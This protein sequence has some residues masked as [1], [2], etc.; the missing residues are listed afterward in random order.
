MRDEST[1]E[2]ALYKMKRPAGRRLPRLRD[3]IKGNDEEKKFRKILKPLSRELNVLDVGCGLGKKY[4]LLES[5]GFARILGVDKNP[6]LVRR[7]VDEGRKVVTPAEFHRSH[8]DTK[9]DLILMSHLIEHF[10]WNELLPFLETYLDHLEDNGF[11]LIVSPVSHTSFY[12]DFDHV[13]PFLPDSIRNIFGPMEQV[14]VRPRHRLELIDLRFRRVPLNLVF[15][16][17]FYVDSANKLPRLFNKLM[18]I[19]FRLS[20]NGIAKTT[21]WLGLFRK[22][23]EV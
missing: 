23:G 15:C 6:D 13:K 11:L 10:Q 16:R 14:Q 21:G 17:S 12:S 22:I 9:F 8:G 4:Q 5:L 3:F 7:N 20:F 18:T 19:L 2:E 1:A